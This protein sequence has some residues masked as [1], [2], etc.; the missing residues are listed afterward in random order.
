MA[1][2]TG[3]ISEY[4]RY[5]ELSRFKKPRSPHTLVFMTEDPEEWFIYCIEYRTKSGEV[6]H[7]SLIIAADLDQWIGWHEGMGW[8]R[9]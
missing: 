8:E 2:K 4:S 9:V 7:D 5:K 6:V 1:R 3:H